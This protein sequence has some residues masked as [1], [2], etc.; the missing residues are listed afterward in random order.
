VHHVTTAQLRE[1]IITA[2]ASGTGVSNACHISL[3]R[4]VQ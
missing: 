3:P 1:Y 4:G 2:I